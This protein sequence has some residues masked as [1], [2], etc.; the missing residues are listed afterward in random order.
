[1]LALIKLKKVVHHPKKNRN[2]N[3][4]PIFPANQTEIQALF[5]GTLILSPLMAYAIVFK[6]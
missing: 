3:P 5:M 6:R 2:Q 1:L 4:P